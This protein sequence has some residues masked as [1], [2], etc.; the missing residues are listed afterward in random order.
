MLKTLGRFSL[1]ALLLTFSSSVTRAD[2][3]VIA[4]GSV[5]VSGIAIGS[6]IYNFSGTNFSVMALGSEHG[7]IGPTCIQCVSG[8]VISTSS[9]F[10]DAGGTV[11]INGMT[12]NDVF[13]V[14][15]LRF[16]GPD[17]I[18]PITDSTTL[19]LTAP[20]TFSGPM[21]GCLEP[22]FR[23]R[24]VVFST[25]LS[26]SGLATIQLDEIIDPQGRRFFKFRNVTYTFTDTTVPEPSSIL[27]LTS[28]IAALVAAKL[29]ARR[30]GGFG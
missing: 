17:V 18:I 21:E 23:C 10:G 20:F 19:T 22:I 25:Q 7:N 26:G 27:F 3:I 9:V 11:T 8:D 28:G 2:P 15:L 24:I 14:G 29:K 13:T 12:F 5:S 1:L 6:P 30:R 4:S 16:T